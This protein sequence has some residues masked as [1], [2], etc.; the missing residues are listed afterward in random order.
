[1]TYYY[2]KQINKYKV[3]FYVVIINE[4]IYIGREREKE[5]IC[6]SSSDLSIVCWSQL[7]SCG[8]WSLVRTYMGPC[9]T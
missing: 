9:P 1:L 5:N 8:F 4:N 6:V 2:Y 3:N 7:T